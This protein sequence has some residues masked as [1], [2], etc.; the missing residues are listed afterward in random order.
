MKMDERKQRILQALILDYIATGDPVGSRTIAKK[1]KLGVSSATIRN[2]MADLEELGLIKQPYTSAGRV[3]SQLGYRYYVDC[4]MEK[5]PL[6]DS[7]KKYIQEVLLNKI[8]ETEALIQITSKLLSQLTN[9]TALVM[10]PTFEKNKLKYIQLLPLT[11]NKVVLVIVLDNGH[12]E[13]RNLDLP[14]SL[15]EEEFQY[16]SHVLNKHLQD[17]SLEQWKSGVLRAVHYELMQQES[18]LNE[19]MELIENVLSLEYNNKVYLGGALNILEQ[20][21]FRD[22][23]KV[24]ELLELLEEE[25]ILQEV[26]NTGQEVGIS[27]KIG[28]ENPYEEMKNCSLITATYELDGKVIGTLGVLGPTRMEYAKAVSIVE[29]LTS[30]LTEGLRKL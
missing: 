9:Y 7:I 6:P 14:F 21:E 28:K 1:Y 18:F 26:L 5:K 10:A 29:F 22:V 12:V 27:V 8:S 17:L 4:L 11:G 3:P 2:E 23:E 15:R 19:V 13:H 20:P 24:K 16:V 25:R 30:T